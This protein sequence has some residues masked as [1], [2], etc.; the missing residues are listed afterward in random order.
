MAERLTRSRLQGGASPT[1]IDPTAELLRLFSESRQDAIAVLQNSVDGRR[2]LFE[3]CAKVRQASTQLLEMVRDDLEYLE[4]TAGEGGGLAKPTTA[5]LP[6]AQAGRALSLLVDTCH[7]TMRAVLQHCD[8]AYAAGPNNQQSTKVATGG[9][10]GGGGCMSSGSPDAVASE[11]IM[12][13]GAQLWR[14]AVSVAVALADATRLLAVPRFYSAFI[15]ADPSCDPLLSI[16]ELAAAIMRQAAAATEAA[17][18]AARAHLKQDVIK[19]E[20]Q[21]SVERGGVKAEVLALAPA[22][23]SCMLAAHG[24]SLLLVACEQQPESLLDA[25]LRQPGGSQ[26][27]QVIARSTLDLAAARIAETGYCGGISNGSGAGDADEDLSSLSVSSFS[28]YLRQLQLVAMRFSELLADDGSYKAMSKRALLP[29][30]AEALLAEPHRFVSWWGCGRDV[31]L[32]GLSARDL[33]MG[34][35]L[36]DRTGGGNAASASATGAPSAVASPTLAAAAASTQPSSPSPQQ[37]LLLQQPPDCTGSQDDKLQT[38]AVG[39]LLKSPAARNNILPLLLACVRLPG[40]GT[41]LA[42]FGDCFLEERFICAGEGVEREELYVGGRGRGYKRRKILNPDAHGVN[43]EQV[44]AVLTAMATAL[45]WAVL[46]CKVLSNASVDP[47]TES[48][49]GAPESGSGQVIGSGGIKPLPSDP[50]DLDDPMIGPRK[51]GG[52]AAAAAATYEIIKRESQGD[53]RQGDGSGATQVVP[54]AMTFLQLLQARC[55]ANGTPVGGGGGSSG[56]VKVEAAGGAPGAPVLAAAYSQ[57]AHMARNLAMLLSL[58][59]PVCPGGGEELRDAIRQQG[60]P[61]LRWPRMNVRLPILVVEQDCELLQGLLEDLTSTAGGVS[62]RQDTEHRLHDTEAKRMQ[63]RDERRLQ[64]EGQEQ[65]EAERRQR[66]KDRRPRDRDRGRV[67]TPTD[68]TGSGGGNLDGNASTMLSEEYGPDGDGEPVTAAAATGGHQPKVRLVLRRGGASGTDVPAIGSPSDDGDVAARQRKR[69]KPSGD[70]EYDED[71]DD[72]EDDVYDPV[73]AARLAVTGRPPEMPYG[74][75]GMDSEE[76]A[77]LLGLQVPRQRRSTRPVRPQ[78]PTP[79]PELLDQRARTCSTAAAATAIATAAAIPP[80]CRTTASGGAVA[81]GG[82]GSGR[83]HPASLHLRQ[84]AGGPISF[85]SIDDSE[86]R[87]IGP[88]PSA[89]AAAGSG[90]GGG[91]PPVQH[92]TKVAMG[93]HGGMPRHLQQQQQEQQQQQ[94]Q[95]LGGLGEGLSPLRRSP[96]VPSGG[97]PNQASHMLPGTT[98]MIGQHPG[99]QLQQHQHQMARQQQQ[100]SA[101]YAM[102]GQPPRQM[103]HPQQQQQHHEH[104]HAPT[105]S[106]PQQQQYL[107]QQQHHYAAAQQSPQYAAQPTQP[108]YTPKQLQQQHYAQQQQQQQQQQRHMEQQQLQQLQQQ[109]MEAVLAGGEAAGFRRVIPQHP[110]YQQQQARGGGGGGYIP[111]QADPSQVDQQRQSQRDTYGLV[112]QQLQYQQQQS[113]QQ[114]FQ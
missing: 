82:P 97:L 103:M 86:D 54:L 75:N 78:T 105:R 88:P 50:K 66:D 109:R 112:Q 35:Q 25:L 108:Q 67:L 46:L 11:G 93:S 1:V 76:A 63:D 28:Y 89:V 104:E 52:G 22:D 40:G 55:G 31:L 96:M 98:A 83:R 8:Q 34:P 36:A 62:R 56:S 49:L 61:S 95:I 84:G 45:E 4:D 32:S 101:A 71:Q 2:K 26:R 10:D 90:G 72:G 77:A 38:A 15:I 113:Y 13:S 64:R 106:H 79:P 87:I 47:P 48:Q 19:T 7:L 17:T 39:L 100:Q 85:T 73:F 23:A 114:Q 60:F 53:T 80:G 59:L 43:T 9:G 70:V 65:K 92:T 16:G 102:A 14:A 94:Q 91:F 20:A 57:I 33:L 58:L 110:Q 41:G 111:S 30:L 51:A 68:L 3:A 29:A 81:G 69:A 107:S 42:A 21:Q 99:Q 5:L 18:S 37:Q 24:S 44:G 6:Q 74:I 12:G 27:L